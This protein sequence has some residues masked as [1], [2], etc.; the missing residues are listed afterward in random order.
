[1]STNDLERLEE[2][3]AEV[4]RLE[5]VANLDSEEYKQLKAMREEFKQVEERLEAD[6]AR[7]GLA[8]RPLQKRDIQV[9][10]TLVKDY[11]GFKDL[12]E[13]DRLDRMVLV[14]TNVCGFG[15]VLVSTIETA[16]GMIP[17]KIDISVDDHFRNSVWTNREG[18]TR[19]RYVNN[20]ASAFKLE[21]GLSIKLISESK[22]RPLEEPIRKSVSGKKVAPVSVKPTSPEE[23]SK[24]GVVRAPE[25]L[26]LEKPSSA[27]PAAAASTRTSAQNKKPE[28]DSGS[29]GAVLSAAEQ[30]AEDKKGIKEKLF[31]FFKK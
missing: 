22:E 16:L 4:D 1:M 8:V 26:V 31:S 25:K 7:R 5:A 13:G 24:Q 2:L 10:H 29:S 18:E 6:L 28:S 30:A 12:S 14:L 9:L 21:P 27:K 20:F 19:R 15:G 23:V 3:R 17:Y 11:P